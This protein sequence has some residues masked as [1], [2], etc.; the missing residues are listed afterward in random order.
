MFEQCNNLIIIK[1]E[2]KKRDFVK[3]LI[4]SIL[5]APK[6]RKKLYIESP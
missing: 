6:R 3:L 5:Y 1:T 4:Y 2:L